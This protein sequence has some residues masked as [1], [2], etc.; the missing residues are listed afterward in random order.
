M[1]GP[2]GLGGG[3]AQSLAMLLLSGQSAASI[4]FSPFTK[5]STR[6]SFAE[7]YLLLAHRFCFS[8]G[9]GSWHQHMKDPHGNDL[10]CGVQA[11][12][13]NGAPRVCVGRGLP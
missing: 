1:Y 2:L 11:L 9:G 4:D 10:Q 6:R 13:H 5:I 3:L 12:C 7:A 8:I